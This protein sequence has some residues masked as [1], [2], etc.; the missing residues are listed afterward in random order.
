LLLIIRVC[1]YGSD[2]ILQ[3]SPK[4]VHYFCEAKEKSWTRD[5]NRD[6]HRGERQGENIMDPLHLRL[7]R[8]KNCIRNYFLR[9]DVHNWL[10]KLVLTIVHNFIHRERALPKTQSRHTGVGKFRIR[11]IPWG[12]CRYCPVTYISRKRLSS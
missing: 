9:T 2:Y 11:G 12:Y 3:I 5:R 10:V 6:R 1:L 4:S 7:R 8:H